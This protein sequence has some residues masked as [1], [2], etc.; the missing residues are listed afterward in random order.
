MVIHRC[1]S[2]II[3]IRSRFNQW[4]TFE[5]HKQPSG[6]GVWV[7]VNRDGKGRPYVGISSTIE[8]L[9]KRSNGRLEVYK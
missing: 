7:R 3:K 5:W 9:I 8:E 6:P 2:K 1:R 4:D